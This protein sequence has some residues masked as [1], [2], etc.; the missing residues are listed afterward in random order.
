MAGR[1]KIG[2]QDD[3]WQERAYCAGD[4][5]G[6][7]DFSAHHFAGM[8]DYRLWVKQKTPVSSDKARSFGSE[9]FGLHVT[10]KCHNAFV[11]DAEIHTAKRT[12]RKVPA[13]LCQTSRR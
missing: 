1:H 6:H 7:R 8:E 3:S 9:E 2:A 10:G 12:K 13:F 4:K 11:D 5:V